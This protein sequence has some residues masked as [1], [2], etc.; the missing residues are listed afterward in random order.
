M[1]SDLLIQSEICDVLNI[2][3]SKLTQNNAK[4]S[5]ESKQA[6][7]HF[8][9]YALQYHKEISGLKHELKMR[10]KESLL[11]HFNPK[12][13]KKLSHPP[14]QARSVSKSAPRKLKLSTKA[15]KSVKKQVQ[16]NALFFK[17]QAELQQIIK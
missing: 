15:A 13:I 11:Q 16:N 3:E 14:I 5:V 17:K 6:T 7:K 9:K 8:K 4:L 1:P 2:D 10:K 12:L